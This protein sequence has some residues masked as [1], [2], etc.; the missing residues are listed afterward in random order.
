MPVQFVTLDGKVRNSR[1]AY[2]VNDLSAGQMDG[3]IGALMP[4]DAVIVDID[5]ANPASA[6]YVQW[7]KAKYPDIFITKTSK[8]GGYHLWFKNA[9]ARKIKRE[10]GLLSIF[11]W[12]F[13]VLTGVRNYIVMPDNFPGR[14]YINGFKSIRELAAGWHDYK[15]EYPGDLNTIMPHVSGTTELLSPLDTKD[16]ERNESLIRWLGYFVAKGLSVDVIQKHTRVLSAI[17]GLDEHEIQS[18][19]L[20]SLSKYEKRPQ[21][22]KAE[23]DIPD[24][25][26]IIGEDYVDVSIQLSKYIKDN[27]LFGFDE[28]TGLGYCNIGAYKGQSL[29]QKELK[30]KMILFF[31]DKLYYVTRDKN[32][33]TRKL[34]KIPNSDRDVIF[35]EARQ[36]I[37]FNSREQQY[38]NIPKWDGRPRI[39]T[40]MKDY[41]E[42]NVN[43][44]F[45]W[46]FLTAIV[47]KLKDPE[48]CY[49]PYHFDFVGAKGVGKTL[50]AHRLSKGRVTTLRKGRSSDDM[51][52]EVYTA[53][54]LI[55]LDDECAISQAMDYN[56]WKQ[57]VT[58]Q[59]DTF[60]RKFQEPETHPR[61]FIIVRTSNNVRTAYTTDERRQIIFESKLQRDCCRIKPGDLPDEYF[62]Q[63]LAE[64][65]E[66]YEKHGVYQLT[67]QDKAYI[68]QQQ[69]E[70]F[71][72]ENTYYHDVSKYISFV[73]EK[74]KDHR[75]DLADCWITTNKTNSG[76]AITWYTYRAW[77]ERNMTREMPSYRFWTQVDA[78]AKLEG[79]VSGRASEFIEVNNIPTRYAEV[80]LTDAKP[81]KR[82]E[83]EEIEVAS[84]VSFFDDNVT[85]GRPEEDKQDGRGYKIAHELGAF[86]VVPYSDYDCYKVID[87]I[88]YCPPDV[89]LF[90]RK[91]A[92]KSGIMVPTIVPA[93]GIPITY[94]LGGV[95][96]A[97]NNY[98]GTDLIHIDVVSMYP[99][100]MIQFDML[101]RA[102]LSKEKFISWVRQRE[103]AKKDGNKE[104]S[105]ELKLKINSVYGY[106]K[107]KWNPLYD[108]FMASSVAV[109]GQILMT[110]L[111]GGLVQTGCEIINVNT[112]GIIIKP[113]GRWLEICNKW[114]DRTKLQLSHKPIQSLEQAD[115]NNYLAI[116]PDGTEIRKGIKY[117]KIT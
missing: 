43:P 101:S 30:Q 63:L 87:L 76:Y 114:S 40:F 14:K 105:D 27:D 38:K 106:M 7:I 53:N 82:L 42:C 41:Y 78:I 16:G 65:K 21:E 104:L 57:I 46:L 62:D 31:G 95:H 39:A 110:I 13:D 10:I 99:N 29:T 80:I 102:A 100:I 33:T 64:A 83:P 8:A 15:V 20:S 3:N 58:L 12:R 66:Y 113:A 98:T 94:G 2:Y 48:H 1:K 89:D 52:V 17:T 36:A 34:N 79:T 107:A 74:I 26:Q 6:Y 56:L 92:N 96:Y 88:R 28:A 117:K 71:D 93:F 81:L 68:T 72:T 97:Q 85:I 11:G 77:C 51:F 45:T 91:Y 111:I 109:T 54:S 32:G 47:G 19:I 18:T 84:I 55:A 24:I 116:L 23:Y 67:E 59:H 5:S 35:E 22:R 9:N 37:K 70:S 115:V 69:A 112:D 61:G 90:F 50:L 4:A 73:R 60:S 86:K 75:F 44:N 108:P 49:V 25:V 103:Q